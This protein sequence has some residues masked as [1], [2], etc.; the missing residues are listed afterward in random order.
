M[1]STESLISQLQVRKTECKTKLEELEEREKDLER[2]FRRDM[3]DVGQFFEF[4]VKN[5]K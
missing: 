5:Y 1:K 3:G 4:F 2:K